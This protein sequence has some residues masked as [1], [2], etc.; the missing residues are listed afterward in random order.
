MPNGV[1]TYTRRCR[2]PS[3][4]P[5]WSKCEQKFS[6]STLI[7]VS[8]DGT[9]EDGGSGLLQVDFANKYLGGG[10]L[11]SGCV[12]EEIRFVICPELFCS[13]LFTEKMDANEAV[14]MMGCERFSDYSGYASTFQFTGDYIDETPRDPYCRRQ[15]TIVA[16]DA[17]RF[18]Q[19]SRQYE[20]ESILRE[21]NKV[22]QR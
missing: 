9:I 14:L 18:T 13:K 7:H 21:L 4:L 15:C 10:V 5:D 17:T 1:I 22:F 3:E 12:Q 16:I 8:S 2:K 20:E 11:K 6:S 19:K